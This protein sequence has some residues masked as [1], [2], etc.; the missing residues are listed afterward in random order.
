MPDTVELEGLDEAKMLDF[1]ADL[2]ARKPSYQITQHNCSHVVAN[3]LLIGTH[4]RPSFTP[5]AGAYAMIGRLA[6]GVWTP[7]QILKFVNELKK[8]S[9]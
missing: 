9:P 8:Q 2:I 3:C 1:V 5:H 7:D 4:R 6:F